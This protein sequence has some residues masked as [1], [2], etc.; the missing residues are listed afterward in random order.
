[1]T[2]EFSDLITPIDDSEITPKAA[3]Q[4]LFWMAVGIYSLLLLI[5][6]VQPMIGIIGLLL[7][8]VAALF[9][10]I[11]RNFQVIG[12]L[13]LLGMAAM[14]IPF[15]LIIY[16]PVLLYF[17][18]K[19]LGY[20]FQHFGL[21]MAGLFIYFFPIGIMA[22]GALE[23]TPSVGLIIPVV[24]FPIILKSFVD[25]RGYTVQKALEIMSEAPILIISIVLPFLKLNIG[26][27]FAEGVGSGETVAGEAA[28]AAKP[29]PNDVAFMKESPIYKGAFGTEVSV[30]EP[31]AT[32]AMLTANS[33]ITVNGFF[34]QLQNSQ[35]IQY[36]DGTSSAINNNLNQ[37][38]IGDSSFENL[39]I[40][41]DGA[42]LKI[43]DSQGDIVGFIKQDGASL[44]VTDTNHFNM[45]SIT[46]DQNGFNITDSFGKSVASISESSTNLDAFTTESITDIDAQLDSINN[47]NITPAEVDAPISEQS[48]SQLPRDTGIN[49]AGGELAVDT[50]DNEADEEVVNRHQLLAVAL[51]SLIANKN[52]ISDTSDKKI[53]VSKR[54]NA[55]KNMIKAQMQAGRAQLYSDDSF[56]A[57]IQ[58]NASDDFKNNDR[59]YTHDKIK[60]SAVLSSGL[61]KTVEEK[62]GLSSENILLILNDAFV[63][64]GTNGM[65]LTENHIHLRA[66]LYETQSFS[67]DEIASL[68]THGIL[69]NEAK[70]SNGQ[71]S[72]RF[73]EKALRVAYKE[74]IQLFKDYKNSR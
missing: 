62:F 45:G 63:F 46:P 5:G 31:V 35:Q 49:I 43:T 4:T 12:I 15:L 44:K 51:L 48:S 58:K 41:N 53:N 2:Q 65:V 26:A 11:I 1:M 21:V 73:Q 36:E 57:Y 27:D 40:Q 74:L 54:I 34:Q 68:N 72:Y 19:R 64:E 14:A 52:R 38:R 56:Y 16:I 13:L 67:I 47:T 17:F 71:L 37:I 20:L 18:I 28:A 23:S 60:D 50:L 42:T 22:N 6:S 7:L 33:A 69:N 24:L 30:S 29:M 10:V 3:Q 70:F 8:G 39:Y 59:I 61:V 9:K 25:N 66:M 32:T 55:S